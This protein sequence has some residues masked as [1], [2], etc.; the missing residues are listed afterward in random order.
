MRSVRNQA[1]SLFWQRG[2]IITNSIGR[3]TVEMLYHTKNV[4]GRGS[5]A[6]RTRYKTNCARGSLYQEYTC[7]AYSS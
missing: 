3:H 4:E 7:Y 6:V 5:D 2:G 1:L